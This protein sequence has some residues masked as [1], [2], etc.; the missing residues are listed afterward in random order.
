[1]P[2]H[3]ETDGRHESPGVFTTR[4]ERERSARKEAERIAERA[5]R[6]LY[7]KNEALQKA[8]MQAE[9]ASLAKSQFLASMSHEIR[10]PIHG[11]LGMAELLEAT[12]LSAEQREYLRMLRFSGESLLGI[13]N[14]ILDFSKIEASQLDLEAIDFSLRERLAETLKA[15]SL[16]A[17][18]K[19]LELACQIAADVPDGLV[20]DPGRLRQMVVNLTSNAIRFTDRGE[21]VVR[22]TAAER[23]ASRVRLDITVTDTG[24]GIPA[25]KL[26]TIFQHFTQVDQSTTRKYGGTGLGLAIVAELAAL[27]SGRVWAESEVGKGSTFH[28]SVYLGVSSETAGR[29]TRVGPEALHDVHALVVDDNATSRCIL[30]QMLGGWGARPVTAESGPRALALLENALAAD[31]PIRV[32]LLDCHMPEMDG[33]AAAERIHSDQRLAAA[34]TIVMLT[35]GGQRGDV[36]RC[37]QLGVAAYLTKPVSQTELLDAVTAAIGRMST[38]EPNAPVVTRRLLRETRSP[39]RILLVEDNRV[40]QKVASALLEKRGHEVVVAENGHAAVSLLDGQPFDLVLM[41]IE[42]PEMDGLEATA[43]IRER[44]RQRGSR[45]LPILAMTAHARAEDRARCLEAG[46]DAYLSKPLQVE[47]LYE[48]VERLGRGGFDTRPGAAPRAVILDPTT[49]LAAFDGDVSLMRRVV[50]VFLDE[51]PELVFKG[52]AAAREGDLRRLW[53][54]AHSIKG[55]SSYFNVP[56]VNDAALNVEATVRAGDEARATAAFRSLTVELQRVQP[57]LRGLLNNP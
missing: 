13:I 5:L 15:L 21:V 11:V 8:R 48:A 49:V 41:D 17:H 56:T 26:E 52:N 19:G 7:D 51:L 39:L 16:H 23:S 22:V 31:D 29:I 54:A 33:F 36:A 24:I 44:E 28:L 14:D 2:K 43:V 9:A 35:S 42:M 50:G 27:M 34:T 57:A 1:M 12:D 45:H 53:D 46:M 25:D 30:T 37:E 55:G 47:T 20:G 32:V 40:N 3:D 4:L 38:V 6:E 10:T 18:A